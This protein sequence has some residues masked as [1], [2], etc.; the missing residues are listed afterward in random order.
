VISIILPKKIEKKLKEEAEKAGVSEEELVL[1]LYRKS[2][3]N[4]L[5]LR[6][7]LKLT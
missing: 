4:P 5:T 2:L 3:M 1:R 7:R 6:Q